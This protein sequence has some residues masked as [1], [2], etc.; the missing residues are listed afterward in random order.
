MQ[1]GHLLIGSSIGLA[2]FG[3]TLGIMALISTDQVL[4][5]FALAMMLIG[6]V[7]IGF[8][9]QATQRRTQVIE[10]IIAAVFIAAVPLGLWWNPWLLVGALALH[11]VWDLLHHNTQRLAAIPQ[12][13]IPLCVL[14]DGLAAGYSGY[15][16]LAY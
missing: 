8:G 2:L 3:V 13:Y 7:Y 10:L 5:L 14:Y 11:G 4:E 9:L 15:F 1:K 12:W 16:L 6:A